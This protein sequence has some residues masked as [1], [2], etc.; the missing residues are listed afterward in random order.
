MSGVLAHGRV[1]ELGDLEGPFQPRSFCESVMVLFCFSFFP[2][3][4]RALV[5]VVT[6]QLLCEWDISFRLLVLWFLCMNR[7]PPLPA[8][9]FLASTMAMSSN[10]KKPLMFY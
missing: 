7:I 1:F 4:C 9:A 3:A 5:V 6:S 10:G 8:L 2:K